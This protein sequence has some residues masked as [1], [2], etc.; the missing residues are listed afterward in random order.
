VLAVVIAGPPGAGKTALLTALSDALADDGVAHAA[1]D[2]DELVWSFPYPTLEQRLRHVAVLASLHQD[3]GHDLILAAEALE[4][5]HHLSLLLGALGAED[6]LTVCLQADV[7]T[8]R[9]RIAAR[10]PEGWSGLAHLLAEADRM[11]AAMPAI[12]GIDLV[13]SS[14]DASPAALAAQVRAALRR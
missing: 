8:L 11:A 2:V 9:A 1:I 10:E 13:L 12:A 14:D 6:S 7:A 3:A 4:S 5:E